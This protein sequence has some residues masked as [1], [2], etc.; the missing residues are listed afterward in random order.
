MQLIII[1]VLTFAVTYILVMAYWKFK[2]NKY[3][4][5]CPACKKGEIIPSGMRIAEWI[6]T[7]CDYKGVSNIKLHEYLDS[8]K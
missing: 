7:E 2:T 1:T 5:S 4:R 3:R 6:C 8:K